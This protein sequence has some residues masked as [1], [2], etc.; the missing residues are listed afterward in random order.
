MRGIALAIALLS[1]EPVR[2]QVMPQPGAGDARIQTIE[3]QPNQVFLIQGAPGYQVTIE[4]AAD[5]RIESVGVGDSG[6]WQVTASRAGAH[7]F[8]K[9]L[10]PGVATNMT[11]VTSARLY[12]FDLQPLGGPSSSMAYTVQFRYPVTATPEQ[13]P[14]PEMAGRY[15]LSGAKSL[16]PER[17]SDDGQ[18]TY[19]EW[20]AD[21]E[22]PAVYMVDARGREVLVNGMMRD[23][24]FV[25]D[26]VASRLVFRI[27]RQRAR[28]TRLEQGDG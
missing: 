21:R 6:A 11:V 15:K 12:V 9:L 2:A 5:E 17:I 25:I 22:L 8:V 13:Q 20:A 1:A 10:Q 27:D 16:R 26:S 24:V 28:A 18:R 7:L 19:I 3:Y 23:D 14:L 4:L